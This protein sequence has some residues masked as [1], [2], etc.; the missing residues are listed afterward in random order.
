M[1]YPRQQHP[2]RRPSDIVAKTA[3]MM[4]RK[5]KALSLEQAEITVADF[6]RKNSKYRALKP[7]DLLK[8]I[9][10]PNAVMEIEFEYEGTVKQEIEI[11]DHKMTRRKF[12]KLLNHE[13]IH[14]N[15][16]EG[17]KLFGPHGVVGKVLYHEDTN[18][19]TQ[20]FEES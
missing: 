6:L 2:L 9:K 5:V 8:K 15:M 10:I 17:G 14:P 20:F 1:T 11:L 16:K 18:M 13:K 3:R 4:Q 19:V 12:L 7:A